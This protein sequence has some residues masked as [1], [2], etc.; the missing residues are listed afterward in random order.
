MLQTRLNDADTNSRRCDVPSTHVDS[1][2]FTGPSP[3][4][5][6]STDGRRDFSTLPAAARYAARQM[7]AAKTVLTRTHT[8]IHTLTQSRYLSAAE[9]TRRTERAAAATYAS[10]MSAASRLATTHACL[11]VLLPTYMYVIETHCRT[12]SVH[13]LDALTVFLSGR[14][15]LCDLASAG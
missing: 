6:T 9:Y 8:H 11:A 12:F 7:T 4:N 2:D 15:A 1:R 5:T 3:I 13:S 10:L 14:V